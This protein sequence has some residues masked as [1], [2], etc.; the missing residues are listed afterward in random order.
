MYTKNHSLIPLANS[1]RDKDKYQFLFENLSKKEWI[2]EQ[3]SSTDSAFFEIVGEEVE[4]FYY[5]VIKNNHSILHFDDMYSLAK[6][7]TINQIQKSLR[8]H[9]RCFFEDKINDKDTSEYYI[10]I[11]SRLINNIRNLYQPRK[12]NV[13]DVP[14]MIISDVYTN[15]EIDFVVTDIE[16]ISKREPLKLIY[17]I[18][19]LLI[20]YEVNV[21]EAVDICHTY[22]IDLSNFPILDFSYQLRNLKKASN[23]QIVIDFYMEVA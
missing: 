3:L 16:K 2:E 14:Y 18:N 9:K 15:Y 11:K 17:A 10:K 5:K 23:N 8:K 1:S 19:L 20:N 21:D 6:Q 12:L 22:N 4:E 7:V 13:L